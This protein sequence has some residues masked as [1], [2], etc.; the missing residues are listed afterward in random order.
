MVLDVDP[1]A[2][3]I[4][5]GVLLTGAGQVWISRMKFE[6]VGLDVPVTVEKT[7]AHPTPDAP[8]NLGGL[9]ELFGGA[10]CPGGRHWHLYIGFLLDGPGTLWLSA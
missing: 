4:A 5:M 10:G 3:G 6:A 9:A 8:V 7:M 1:K 2:T